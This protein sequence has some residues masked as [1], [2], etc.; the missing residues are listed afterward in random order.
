M[1]KDKKRKS[2]KIAIVVSN[3]NKLVT[4]GL[5]KGA[6]EVIKES[7]FD[8]KDLKIIYCPGAFEI[9]LTAKHLCESGKYCAVICLGAVI[10][11]ETA[12]FDYISDAV[13][14]GILQLNLEFGIPVTF[15]VL[16]CYTEEQAIKR[17]SN[18]AE[19]KGREAAQTAIEMIKLLKEI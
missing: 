19:N 16:T 15:G 1:A 9:P 17:S 6:L 2:G 8:E 14:R 11:G 4:E 10:K 12:H 3:Y 5:L 7:D 18:D 13:T